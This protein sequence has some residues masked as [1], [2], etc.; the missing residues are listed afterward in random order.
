MVDG[1]GVKVN[2][3]LPRLLKERF[4]GQKTGCKFSKSSHGIHLKA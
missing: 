4:F 1:E 2:F 3:M